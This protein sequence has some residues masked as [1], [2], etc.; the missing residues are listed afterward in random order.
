MKENE[1]KIIIK[2]R[3]VHNLK[4]FRW[5]FPKISLWF[6]PACPEAENP[7]WLLTPI[8]AEGQRRYIESLSPYAR[9][10]LGQ[11]DRPDVDEITDLS[12]AIAI[13]QRSSSQSSFNRGHPYGNLR[14]SPCFIRQAWRSVL[15]Y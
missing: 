1:I 11:M 3:E 4:M 6:L 5:K 10:F 15:S 7:V 12:P 2:G 13:D 14:L 8:F 9:Q